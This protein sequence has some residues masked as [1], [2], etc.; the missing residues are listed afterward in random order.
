MR[1]IG[2]VPARKGSKRIQNKNLISVNKKSLLERVFEIASN[3][4]FIDELVVSTDSDEIMKL[5]RKIGFKVPFKRPAQLSKDN[6]DSYD[7]IKHCL[8]W[9]KKN[10]KKEF[11]LFINLQ[12]TSPFR[13][14]TTLN[15]SF[16]I[17]TKEKTKYDSLVTL[18][19][20]NKDFLL[21]KHLIVDKNTVKKLS[22][23]SYLIS[24]DSYIR[25]G[26]INPLGKTSNIFKKKNLYGSKCYGFII[27]DNSESIDINT[28]L[29]HVIAE[30]VAREIE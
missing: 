26:N 10:Q 1:V 13:K 11:D 25:D 9:Y 8:A 17:F 30:K 27:R 5:S 7:V 4:S 12:P 22:N 2:I 29:D 20:I 23:N 28:H 24:K 19:K 14:L 3:C 21:K 6:T 15:K 18:T 16:K